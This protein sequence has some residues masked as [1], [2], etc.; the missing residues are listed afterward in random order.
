MMRSKRYQFATLISVCA[1]VLA[2]PP[3][4]PSRPLNDIYLLQHLNRTNSSLHPPPAA[5]NYASYPP[6]SEYTYF[7]NTAHPHIEVR[8]TSFTPVPTRSE[9][10]VSDVF[11]TA[12]LEASNPALASVNVPPQT[13]SGPRVPYCWRCAF[14]GYIC[15]GRRG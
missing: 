6:Q 13:S 1:S 11:R 7:L 5:L 15:T 9:T 4:R 3:I 10:D 14:G 8:F 12:I 2:A